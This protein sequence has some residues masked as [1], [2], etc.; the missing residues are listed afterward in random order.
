MA[1]IFNW[2]CN[3]THRSN[4]KKLWVRVPI[5]RNFRSNSPVP[6]LTALGR[7]FLLLYLDA[8]SRSRGQS[9]PNA[10]YIIDVD[11]LFYTSSGHD[12][13]RRPVENGLLFWQ[14]DADSLLRVHRFLN[15]GKSLHRFLNPRLVLWQ[16]NLCMS[17][18]S[19][20]TLL[21]FTFAQM[22]STC[23]I[24]LELNLKLYYESGDLEKDFQKQVVY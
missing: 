8:P 13:W 7:F 21:Y 9:G 18:Q 24:Q 22:I 5:Y 15:V 3:V 19:Q 6:E 23:S 14:F 20:T 11:S 2:T 12:S 16:H 1:L 10:L 4:Y 17:L